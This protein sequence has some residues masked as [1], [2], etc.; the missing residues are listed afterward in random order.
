MALRIELK[1]NER[2]IIGRIALT[3]GPSRTSFTVEGRAPI[4][5]CKDIIT[6][7][8][9]DTA[10]KQLYLLVERVYLEEIPFEAALDRFHALAE[11]IVAAAPSTKRF[12][13]VMT[14]CFAQ[15]SHY[16]AL[17]IGRKLIEYEASLIKMSSEAA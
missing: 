17:K 5:R 7:E 9:A 12:L 1:P 15:E 2:I 10:C 16:R 14:A 11:Q 4:L 6:P 13:E 3:N 8:Q